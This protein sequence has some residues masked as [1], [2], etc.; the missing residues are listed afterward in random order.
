MALKTVRAPPN[1]LWA[2]AYEIVPPQSESRLGRI[3]TLIDGEQSDARQGTGTW[4]GRF[5]LD[6]EITHILVVSDSPDQHREVNRQLEAELTALHVPFSLTA[7]MAVAD[8]EPA[9][10]P[11]YS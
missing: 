11:R 3:Q 6:Q 4:E 2:Y 7:S 8:D 5:V 9:P 10:L 1:A